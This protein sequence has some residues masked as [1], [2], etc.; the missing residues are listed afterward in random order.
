M[1]LEGA[2][3]ETGAW[4]SWAIFA[5]V[6]IGAYL[7]VMWAAALYWTYRD[8]GSRSRDPVMQG[9]AVGTVLIFNLPGLLLYLILRPKTTLTERYEQRLE[10]EALLHEIREQPACPQCRRKVEDDYVTC[11][12]CRVALRTA[13]E[14]CGKGL[15]FGWVACPYCG[16]DR[17]QPEPHPT[18]APSSSSIDAPAEPGI[19]SIGRPARRASTAT[20]TP[21]ASKAAADPTPAIEPA[22]ET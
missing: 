16:T 22:T 4:E 19:T 12:Y 18:R 5:G 10:A 3:W 7:F 6:L 1:L 15:A 17:L 9:V 13:C 20:Y 14:S 21:P 8:S 2:I 11:P